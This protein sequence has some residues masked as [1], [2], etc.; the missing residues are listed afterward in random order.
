[1]ENEKVDHA[2]AWG[3]LRVSFWRL[4]GEHSG[5][6]PAFKAGRLRKFSP[7]KQQSCCQP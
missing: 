3:I 5:T 7:T 4:A 6:R 1:M 2:L